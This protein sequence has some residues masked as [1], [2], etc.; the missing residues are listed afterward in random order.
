MVQLHNFKEQLDKI[1]NVVSA[2]DQAKFGE[3]INQAHNEVDE[4]K[5]KALG[6]G[7]DVSSCTASETILDDLL[8]SVS[9]KDTACLVAEYDSE[10]KVVTTAKAYIEKLQTDFLS[11]KLDK[12]LLGCGNSISC[13]NEF[14]TDLGKVSV[15]IPAEVTD[16]LLE[17]QIVMNATPKKLEECSVAN[18]AE[19]TSTSAAIVQSVSDCAQKIL[20]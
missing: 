16:K 18:L 1:A 7:L 4:W 17:V 19:I 11:F 13:I 2:N 3:I 10:L 12:I 9:D 6:K 20:G 14:N 5:L 8:K 15:K